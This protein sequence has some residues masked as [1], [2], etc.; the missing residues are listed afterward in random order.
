MPGRILAFGW[1]IDPLC[2]VFFKASVI[3]CIFRQLNC[4]I[5]GHVSV[6]IITKSCRLTQISQE[7][8]FAVQND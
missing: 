1:P 4:S 3:K 8:L 5:S 2:Q 6:L 7:C